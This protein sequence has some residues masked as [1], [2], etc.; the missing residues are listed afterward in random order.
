MLLL[1][2]LLVKCVPLDFEA[3]GTFYSASLHDLST[4]GLTEVDKEEQSR[5]SAIHFFANDGVFYIDFTID[6]SA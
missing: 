1:A 3:L 5:N 4:T 6:K 2:Y